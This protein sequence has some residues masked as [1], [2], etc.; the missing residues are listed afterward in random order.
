M[1]RPAAS[2][3][4]CKHGEEADAAGVGEW[5]SERSAAGLSLPSLSQN[6][7]VL[8]EWEAALGPPAPRLSLTDVTWLQ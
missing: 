2:V 5:G 8:R 3:L 1:L 4:E 6:V 7:G